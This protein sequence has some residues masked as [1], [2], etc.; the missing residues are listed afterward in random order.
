LPGAIDGVI[1]DGQAGAEVAVRVIG[2]KN[3][4]RT[5][6]FFTIGYGGRSPIEFLEHLTRAGV[7]TI[8]DVRLRP[9]KASMGSYC[10]AKSADRGIEALLAS[11]GIA[12]RSLPELGNVFLGDDEW[13]RLYKELIEKAGSLLTRRLGDVPGPFC[14][15]CAEKRV[16]E[17]HRRIIADFLVKRGDEVTHLE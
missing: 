9:D 7:K 13:P 1:H 2:P 15:L 8:V 16:A 10:R 5:V 3:R 17:C 11:K 6:R 4:G 12:Y 14:L